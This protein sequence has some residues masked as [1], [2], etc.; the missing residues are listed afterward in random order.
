M[1]SIEQELNTRFTSEQMRFVMNMMFTASWMRNNTERFLEPYGLSGPQFNILRI[2][3]GANDWLSMNT[4]KE[5]M[6][7]KS[8]HT[9]RLVTKLCDK[10]LVDRNRSESDRRVV[11]VIITKKG[12]DMLARIDKTGVGLADF[13]DNVS[14]KEA[15]LASDII[16]KLRE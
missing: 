14:D 1:A 16:D 11:N 8:P 2:L 6:V 15:R 10:E 12:L 5:R 4:I 9:T 13:M 7:E 3:R